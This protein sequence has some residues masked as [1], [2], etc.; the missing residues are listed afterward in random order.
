MEIQIMEGHHD[1]VKVVIQCKKVSDDILRLKKHIGRFQTKLT[2]KMDQQTVFVELAD[3][4]YFESVDN[5]VFLYTTN[6]VME[7]KERLYELEDMLPQEDFFRI[8]KAQIVNI[9]QI[10][11]LSPGF[12]RTLL[13]T[14]TNGEQVYISRKYATDLRKL[15]SI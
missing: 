2:A 4:L 14:M 11:V 10:K 3:V 7:V 12:N 13:A 6:A 1:T 9:Q 8:S 5:R 15:L